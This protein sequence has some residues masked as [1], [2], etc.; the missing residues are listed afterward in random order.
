MRRQRVWESA[1][2]R[3][4]LV[5]RSPCASSGARDVGCPRWS[6]CVAPNAVAVYKACVERA[7]RGLVIVMLVLL[8]DR[9]LARSRGQV[10][11]AAAVHRQALHARARLDDWRRVWQPHVDG[12]GQPSQG[13]RCGVMRCDA[14]CLWLTASST[15]FKYGIRRDRKSF[16][17]SRV[18]TT[19][20]VRGCVVGASAMPLCLT[21]SICM[22]SGW[23]AAS[24]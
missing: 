11:L 3:E 10:V 20:A 1:E 6:A 2:K 21:F 12:G 22:C 14:V 17:P 24:L 8:T 16:A 4:M 15:S 19:A 5:L 7:K 9:P 18:R 23:R 13:K